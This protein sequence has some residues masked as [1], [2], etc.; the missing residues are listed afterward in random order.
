MKQNTNAMRLPVGSMASRAAARALLMARVQNPKNLDFVIT[1]VGCP[2]VYNPPI[3]GE[4]GNIQ[5]AP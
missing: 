2:D 4:G 1:C 3:V 5:T